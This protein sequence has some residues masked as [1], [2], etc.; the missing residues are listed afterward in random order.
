MFRVS[1][2]VVR[3]R[4]I[5][6]WSAVHRMDRL[7]SLLRQIARR[8]AARLALELAL[9]VLFLLAVEAFR[10]QDV[11]SGPLP[12]VTLPDRSGEFVRLR[13]LR[14]KPTMLV[15]WAPWCGVCRIESQN[16]SWVQALVGDRARVV[17][18]AAAYG[19]PAEVEE[20]VRAADVDYQVLLGGRDGARLLG[21][22]A[23]PTTLFLDSS[24]HVKH[25]ATGYTTT[26]GLILRLLF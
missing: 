16:V 1:S 18:L 6:R 20:F 11:P 7:R 22:R 10:A 2:L 13:D 5:L 8:P 24:G 9:L 21:V 12:A 4:A 26:L 25:V 14:G 15:V 3:L 23:F 19:R 17:S